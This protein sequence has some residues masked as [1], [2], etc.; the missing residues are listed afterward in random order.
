MIDWFDLII[1]IIGILIIFVYPKVIRI[2]LIFLIGYLSF[3]YSPYFLILYIPL[4]I[5]M[6]IYKRRKENA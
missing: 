1:G 2:F 3:F 4:L 6:F 5:T